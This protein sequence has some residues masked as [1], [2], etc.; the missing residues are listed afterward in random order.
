MSDKEYCKQ[1]VYSGHRSDFRGHRCSKYAK[2]DGYCGIH[3]PD[4]AK[5]RE[6]A[7]QEKWIRQEESRP[8]NIALKRIAHLEALI[9]EYKEVAKAAIEYR[10]ETQVNI[11]EGDFL[12]RALESV[13][14]FGE[15]DNG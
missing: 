1:H 13:G 3:H 2:K 14:M 5:R 12:D 8:I 10:E 4:A 6:L 11:C 15:A 7:A 9:L